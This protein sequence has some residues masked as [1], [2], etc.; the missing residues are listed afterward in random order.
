MYSEEEVRP[1]QESYTVSD[2]VNRYKTDRPRVTS[3]FEDKFA[4]L[5]DESTSIETDAMNFNH[6]TPTNAEFQTQ[7]NKLVNTEG[8]YF[9]ASY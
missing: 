1:Q 5:M 2:I 7:A 4:N 8:R 9:L 3:S 6:P